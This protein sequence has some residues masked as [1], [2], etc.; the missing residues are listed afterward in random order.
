MNDDD[1]NKNENTNENED[2]SEGNKENEEEE[3][4]EKTEINFNN[5]MQILN[6]LAVCLRKMGK[7]VKTIDF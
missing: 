4:V 5:K 6:E 1:Q 3:P 2:S 7:R